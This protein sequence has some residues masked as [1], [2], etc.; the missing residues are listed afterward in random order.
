VFNFRKARPD[1]GEGGKLEEEAPN[2]RSMAVQGDGVSASRNWSGFPS[3]AAINGARMSTRGRAP[4]DSMDKRL[5]RL[6]DDCEVT[7]CYMECESE[8]GGLL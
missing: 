3:V 1:C 8:Y 6:P 4:M 2:K 7:V 5:I